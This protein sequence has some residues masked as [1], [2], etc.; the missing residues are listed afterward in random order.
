MMTGTPSDFARIV[1][2]E[3]SLPISETIPFILLVS[4]YMIIEGT[5]SLTTRI[6]SR[7]LMRSVPSS[8]F[9][10]LIILSET[11]SIS[12]PRSLKKILSMF[13]NVSRRLFN[14][15]RITHSAFLFLLVIIDGTSS[16]KKGSCVMSM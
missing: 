8:P 14:P 6:P 15:S 4:I 5:S 10:F 11:S 13:L 16:V 9:N 2:C 12:L 3:V 7:S 1:A